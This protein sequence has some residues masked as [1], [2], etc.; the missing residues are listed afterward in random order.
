MAE[1][2][3]QLH[4]ER[5]AFLR[6]QELIAQ[7]QAKIVEL[8][9]KFNEKCEELNTVN[10]MEQM[11]IDNDQLTSVQ[12]QLDLQRKENQKLL[13]QNRL[14]QQQLAKKS[15]LMSSVGHLTE[16]SELQRKT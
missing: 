1:L 3:S 5:E 14:F 12:S 10:Q 6:Q 4:D 11:N 7:L 9:T 16:Q 2:E 15:V 8:E 13:Q